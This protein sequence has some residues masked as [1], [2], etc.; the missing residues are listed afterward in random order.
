M[1]KENLQIINTDST[2]CYMDMAFTVLE[3]HSLSGGYNFTQ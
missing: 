3:E 2:M 1:G